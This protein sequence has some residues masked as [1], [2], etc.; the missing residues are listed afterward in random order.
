MRSTCRRGIPPSLRRAY[1]IISVVSSANPDMSESDCNDYGTFR[2]ARV[3][4][5]RMGTGAVALRFS[6]LGLFWGDWGGG[7]LR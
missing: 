3:I 2:K 7:G 4:G 1:W 5:E 6:L